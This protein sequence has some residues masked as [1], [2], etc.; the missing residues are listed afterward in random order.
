MGLYPVIA[1]PRGVVAHVLAASAIAATVACLGSTRGAATEAPVRHHAITTIGPVKHG[2]GYAHFD[3]VNPTAP[4]GGTLRLAGIGKFD[5]LNRHTYRGVAAPYLSLISDTLMDPNPDEPATSYGLIAEWVSTPPD[6][7]SATFGLRA[8]ARFHDGTPITP[9]DVIFSLAEQKKAWPSMAILLRDVTSAEKTGEREVTF[10]FA[11]AGSRDLPLSVGFLPILPRH[12][13][14]AKGTNGEPRDLV[15]STLE[16]PLGSGPYRIKSVDAGRSIVYERVRDYWARDLPVRRGQ[17]NFDEIRVAMYRDD[18]PEFEALKAGDIDIHPENSSKRWATQYDIPA[19]RDG[20]LVKLVHKSGAVAQM[21]GFVLNTRRAK[22]ADPRVRRAFALAYDFESANTSLF[23][24]LYTRV[25]S[26]FDN[27]ELAPR[28]L[29]EGREL[30]LLEKWRAEVPA[31][32]FGQPYKSPVNATPAQQRNNLREAL[33]LL[34][35]AGWKVKSGVLRHEKTGEAMT[36]EYLNYD[37]SFDRIV[38][39]YQR[40][41]AKIGIRL[42]IRVV[43]ATQYEERAKKYDFEMIGDVYPQ[44]HAPGNE[45]RENFGS[46]AADRPA[47]RNRI[48]L[49][50]PAVD[51]LIEEVIYAPDRPRVVAAARAL[52]RVLMWSHTIVPQWYNSDNWIVHS[53]RL[54]RPERM[55]SQEPAWLV[56][57]WMKPQ[58]ANGA[59][60]P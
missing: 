51:A 43:D 50:G 46:A 34:G 11:R 44:S 38:L 37:T 26:Y 24:G 55:P 18:I 45:L 22:F 60:A 21:Q 16:T 32:V 12:Y 9:E 53:S 39:P 40:T 19:V 49:K 14:T 52:D 25:N 56:A 31:E 7:S 27:S 2:P 1:A 47:S 30:E 5:S 20:R 59:K 10:R 36:V 28:G 23:Y 4:K 15:R 29:P 57:W 13:W 42:A 48:G 17:Y 35:E 58:L 6:V 8:E 3:W 41:L 54:G 33:R